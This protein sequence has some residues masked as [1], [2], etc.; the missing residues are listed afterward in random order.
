MKRIFPLLLLATGLKTSVQAETRNESAHVHGVARLNLV[1][2]AKT[3]QLEFVVP[4][5]DFLGFEH[6]PSS[7][8][9]V[10]AFE[11]LQKE[12]K[13]PAELFT[14][15][16][17]ASCSLVKADLPDTP[18]SEDGHKKKGHDH[19]KKDHDHDEEHSDL[20]AQYSFSCQ[21]PEKVASIKLKVFDRF[22][23]LRQIKALYI[24]GSRQGQQMLK[25]GSEV[26]NFK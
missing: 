13:K 4:A 7:D 2:E 12:L 5:A 20:R 6:K 15:P 22:K 11:T 21:N 14:L 18:W 3:L 23:S 25:P 10:R 26:L 17:E 24:H 19:K 1:L 8:S 16:E 9:E